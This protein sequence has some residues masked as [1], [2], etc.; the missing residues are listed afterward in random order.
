[1]KGIKLGINTGKI[2]QAE[3]LTSTNKSGIKLIAV[4]LKVSEANQKGFMDI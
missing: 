4:S 3:T 1:V 2:V